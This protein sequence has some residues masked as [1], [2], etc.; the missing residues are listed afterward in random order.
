MKVSLIIS[1][2]KNERNLELIFMSLGMQS[3]SDFEVIIAEDDNDQ[4]TPVFIETLQEKY[5][6][7]IT[8]ISQKVDDGFRKNEMLNRAIIA[9]KAQK[10][11]FIDGDCIPH[12]HFIR[13]YDRMISDKLI[14]FG[15][16]VNLGEKI[17]QQIYDAKNLNLLSIINLVRSDS[18]KIKEGFYLPFSLKFKNTGL[19]GCNWGILKSHLIE[20][21]G[22]DEDYTAAGVGEDVDIEW[23]L[24]EKGLKLK[25][26]K[27]RAIVYHLYH[28]RGYSEAS[29]QFNYQMLSDKKVL[30]E[31]VCVNGILKY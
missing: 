16:R 13:T 17:T 14:C 10:I 20:V 5:S 22:F 1:Y 21:N 23:R 6:F 31:I 24:R 7:P 12:R 9:A 30:G 18:G 28:P 29:V 19:L 15:K 27:N 8:L 4:H 26:T 11:C 2:Y 3:E 25:S